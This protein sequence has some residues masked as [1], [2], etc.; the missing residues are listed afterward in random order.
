MKDA[1]DSSILVAAVNPDEAH[2][3]ACGRRL[4]GGGQVYL[5]GLVESFATLTGGRSTRR[6]RPTEADRLLRESVLPFVKV[7]TLSS[8]QTLAALGE[9]A[10][11]GIMGG[12]IYDYLH[13]VAARVAKAPRFYTLDVPHFQAFHRAGDPE[14]VHP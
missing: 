4:D 12:A 3:A 10:A 11:R 14:I 13:L 6:L 7:I 8:A 2:H 9:T 5:H 1:F